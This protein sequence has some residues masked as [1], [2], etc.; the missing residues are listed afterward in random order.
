[1]RKYAAK[2]GRCGKWDLTKKKSSIKQL[3][4]SQVSNKIST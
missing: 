3:P 1:M 4:S 2:K